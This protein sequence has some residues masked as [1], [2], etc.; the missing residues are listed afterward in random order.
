M[1]WCE[2]EWHLAPAPLDPRHSATG[3]QSPLSKA[4]KLQELRDTHVA[5]SSV[6]VPLNPSW[7]LNRGLEF[8]FAL[9]HTNYVVCPAMVFEVRLNEE[10]SSI[11]SLSVVL[12]WPNDGEKSCWINPVFSESQRDI[13]DIAPVLQSW[14]ICRRVSLNHLHLFQVSFL[15]LIFISLL[16][17]K[18]QWK[19]RLIEWGRHRLF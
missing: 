14:G 17:S 4:C 7:F 9:G 16:R 18:F 15:T 6:I 5:S 2:S 8:Y 19:W 12:S 13:W 1:E 10:R 3:A 11:V